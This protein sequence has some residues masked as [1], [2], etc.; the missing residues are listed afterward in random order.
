MHLVFLLL[1][2]LLLLLTLLMNKKLTDALT[3]QLT[4]V[5]DRTDRPYCEAWRDTGFRV[6]N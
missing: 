5:S 4:E 3:D 6:L 1:L 2:L